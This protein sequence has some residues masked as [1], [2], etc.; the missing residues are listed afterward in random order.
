MELEKRWCEDIWKYSSTT[1]AW[2][3]KSILLFIISRILYTLWPYRT[4][5]YFI[6]F[7]L[8]GKTFE[9]LSFWKIS[10]NL[11][12]IRFLQFES[13]YLNVGIHL[14]K[15]LKNLLNKIPTGEHLFKSSRKGRC[16]KIGQ[17]DFRYLQNYE[18]TAWINSIIFYVHAVILIW[19]VSCFLNKSLNKF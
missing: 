16:M 8:I 17:K 3:P 9:K 15:Y 12:W 11:N 5:L 4:S 19:L 10:S 7:W 14:S 2:K 13:D 18:K 6:L 1:L